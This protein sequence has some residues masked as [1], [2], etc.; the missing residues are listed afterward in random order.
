MLHLVRLILALFV[1]FL[2]TP[3]VVCLVKN[4][5]DTSMA[6]N[7]AEEE[8][9]VTPMEEIKAGFV[10]DYQIHIPVP[11]VIGSNMDIA[12][13]LQDYIIPPDSIIIPPPELV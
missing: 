13:L 9:V 10:S 4:S 5:C 1:F 11:T 3:T 7:L 6:Y 12:H 8:R 2:A